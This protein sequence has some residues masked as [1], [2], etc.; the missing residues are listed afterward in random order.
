MLK[1]LPKHYYNLDLLRIAMKLQTSRT[2]YFFCIL[3]LKSRGEK[4][5]IGKVRRKTGVWPGRLWAV[6][7]GQVNN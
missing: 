2:F 1:I 6:V 4:Y 3:R 5:L 7:L